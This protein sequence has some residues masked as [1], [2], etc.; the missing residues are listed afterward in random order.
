M[1]FKFYCPYCGQH[2][3]VDV[4]LS[5]SESTCP[6]CNKTISVP[7]TPQAEEFPETNTKPQLIVAEPTKPTSFPLW[8]VLISVLVLFVV[9]II[10]ATYY[11]GSQQ[12]GTNEKQANSEANEIV[13][14]KQIPTK[15]PVVITTDPSSDERLFL[16]NLL[17][18]MYNKLPNSQA[19]G[20]SYQK[21]L[22]QLRFKANQ[23][24]ED[25]KQ[26]NLDDTLAGMYTDFIS[27]VDEYGNIFTQYGKIERAAVAREEKETMESGFNAGFSGGQRIATAH[28]NGDSGSSAI[29]QGAALA[30]GQFLWDN[31]N[32]SKERDQVKADALREANQQFQNSYSTYLAKAQNGA[33]YLSQK[34]SWQTGEAG[35]DGSQTRRRDP[36]LLCKQAYQNAVTRQC[37]PKEMLEWAKQCI[38][39]ADLVPAGVIYDDYRADFLW[40]AGVIASRASEIKIGNQQWSKAYNED[41]AYAVQI[42][43]ACL[44]YFSDPIGKCRA[45]LAW[46]HIKTGNLAEAFRLANEVYPLLKD[47]INYCYHMACL[48]S[49]LHDT[50]TSF[51]WIE[52][53]INTLG[54][55]NVNYLKNDPNL[56]DVRAK[57]KTRF[58]NLVTVKL[59]WQV[60]YGVLFDDIVVYNNSA[61][62]V[63][64]VNFNGNFTSKDGRNKNVRL[65][66]NFI[67]AGKSYTW[68]NATSVSRDASGTTTITTKQ[69][70]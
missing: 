63:T 62:S 27:V 68:P 14:P 34:Y 49:A 45:R 22:G 58:D 29:M 64:D 13:S 43:L 69:N 16:V 70:N 19:D 20:Q 48:N 25:I 31:Y 44:K 54:Y 50:D 30:I 57:Q 11:G 53:I 32:R 55:N 26:R 28:D 35:F 4:D 12:G 5:G 39:A 36:F 37:P 23:R 6:S 2:I 65:A 66:V 41:A 24:L 9:I 8:K 7:Q 59:T 60:V 61:F 1:D 47:D 33:L 42:W 40:N 46:E 67:G 21:T 10:F 17:V 38:Y 18:S 51:K 3:L 56:E 52:Y 15:E